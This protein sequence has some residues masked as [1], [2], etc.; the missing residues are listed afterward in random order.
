MLS[1]FAINAALIAAAL[2]LMWLL[3]LYLQDV[4]I[5]DLFWGLGFVVIAWTTF[6][7]TE[8]PEEGGVFPTR[9]LLPL[10]TTIWGLRLSL[11]LVRRNI[12]HAEDKRYRAM[13][14]S[15]GPQFWWQSLFMVFALQGVIMLVVSLPLQLGIA[16]PGSGWTAI[17]FVGL[18]V[19][20][21]G[22]MFEA[23]G[24]WQLATFRSNPENRGKVCS[25]GLWHYTRH[26]N[27]FGDFC[28]W[29]GYY[30]IAVAHGAHLWTAIGPALMSAFLMKW[31]GVGLLEKSL[32]AEKPEYAEYMRRTNTFFPGPP[33]K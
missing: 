1:L 12:G 20:L 27:Y 17:H 24:D 4:S 15:I 11:H 13:R 6:A 29:W 8:V 2:F 3:S 25:T 22:L 26:P 18:T 28:V 19:W 5:I 33:R 16:H 32:K 30:F 7:L 9:W 31:S 14:E 23:I 21:I 10:V